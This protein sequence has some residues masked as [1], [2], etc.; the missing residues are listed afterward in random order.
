ME[1]VL[2]SLT[3]ALSS[4][5]AVALAAAFVWGV[6]SMILS[7]CHL[8][9]IPL[10]VGF[11]SQKNDQSPGTAFRISFL[12]AVGILISIAVIGAITAAMGRIL[13]DIG[14][15]LNYVVAAVFLF[16]GLY[17]LG[18]I[19]WPWAGREL[20]A[21]IGAGA[22]AA[23][24]IGLLFGLSLGPCTF[25]Y[26]AP[27]LGVVFGVSAVEPAFAMAMLAAFALGHCSVILLAGM[28]TERVQSYLKWTE[29]TQIAVSIRKV[30]GLLVIAGAVYLVYLA[31]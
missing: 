8:A 12:F 31:R 7:P 3:G 23:L 30:S 1:A 6:L 27:M 21:N 29:R 11:V 18:F 16:V 10:V 26:M 25:A 22:M 24:G 28:L 4:V 13:G 17:L 9:S 15:G 2:A 14:T 20:K 5:S 19:E